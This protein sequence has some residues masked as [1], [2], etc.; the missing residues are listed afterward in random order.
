MNRH[1]FRWD[2]IAFGLF[3][4]AVLGQWAVSETDWLAP[5]DLAYV[6]AVVLIVLGRAGYR[7]HRHQRQVRPPRRPR[8]RQ[9]PE[10]NPNP[11]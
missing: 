10:P 11:N 8:S 9:R 5:D 7:R 6:A 4:L 2:A 1:P 3:F